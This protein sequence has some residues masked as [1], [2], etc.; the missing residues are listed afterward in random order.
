MTS[1]KNALVL[2]L[3][4]VTALV[5]TL[6][7]GVPQAMA[8]EIRK[9]ALAA[10]HNA[11][12]AALETI[13]ENYR[14]QRQIDVQELMNILISQEDT[15]KN[16][17]RIETQSREWFAITL[18]GD[19]RSSTAA[20][21][22]IQLITVRDSSYSLISNE[23]A[24][25][26]FSFPA[27]VALSKI[28]MPAVEYLLDLARVSSPTSTAFHLSA[29]TLEAILSPELAV[30]AVEQ[31]ARQY[32]DFSHNDRLTVLTNLIQE[33]HQR[34]SANRAADFSQD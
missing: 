32:P 19:L 6:E 22:L 2:N 34:W 4:I 5:F 26:W 21:L 31:Y 20:P 33:G 10:L 18:L 15:L 27:A 24:P 9:S 25:D 17:Q 30:V 11:S 28:G 29:L 3:L 13:V 14:G 12:G 7:T 8:Q 23:S 16:R 1:E